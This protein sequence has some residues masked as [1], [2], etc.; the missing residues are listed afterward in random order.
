ME[1]NWGCSQKWKHQDVNNNNYNND[2][3]HDNKGT[4]M[5]M[6]RLSIEEILVYMWFKKKKKSLRIIKT[7]DWAILHLGSSSRIIINRLGKDLALECENLAIAK[8]PNTK[9]IV[10]YYVHSIAY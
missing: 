3:R 5:L 10:T 4:T 7:L 1:E 8:I 9:E 2:S 6:G